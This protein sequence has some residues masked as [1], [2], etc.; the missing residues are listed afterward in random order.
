M[1]NKTNVVFFGAAGCGE[2]YCRNS[3]ITPDIF[4]DNDSSKW[5]TLFNGIEVMD[6][7]VLASLPLAKVVVTSSYL[8][9]VWRHSVINGA[10]LL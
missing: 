2:A 3:G 1:E 10:W 8:K 6:P 7:A 9:E 5:G 4:V